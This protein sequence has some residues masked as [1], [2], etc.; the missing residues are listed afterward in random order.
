[1]LQ[2]RRAGRQIRIVSC[3]ALTPIPYKGGGPALAELIGRQVQALFSLTLVATPQVKAGKVRALAIA[4]AK[5]TRVAP[6]QPTV[7]ELG[8]PGF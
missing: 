8:F 6:D 1:L 3:M 2:R 7:A 4:S 5:R